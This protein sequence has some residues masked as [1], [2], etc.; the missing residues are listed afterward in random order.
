MGWVYQEE[1][2]QIR[3]FL[4]ESKSNKRPSLDEGALAVTKEKTEVAEEEDSEPS[5]DS[6]VEAIKQ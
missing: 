1:R 3:R 2:Y 5:T 4:A 6:K